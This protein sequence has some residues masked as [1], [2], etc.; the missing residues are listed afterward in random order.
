MSSVDVP[1][2]HRQAAEVIR[3]HLVAHRGG[4]VFLS[5]SDALRLI[6]WLDRE[7]P[8]PDILRAIERAADNRAK[9]RSRV[10]LGL[11]HVGRHLGKPTK[12][13]FKARGAPVVA[14]HETGLAPLVR[15]ICERAPGDAL[16]DR[17]RALADELAALPEGPK[18]AEQAMIR[19]RA[20]HEAVFDGL[21][22]ARRSEL[23]QAARDA[24]AD[25]AHL[26]QERELVPLI[27]EAARYEARRGYLWLSAASVWDLLQPP[28]SS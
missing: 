18:L 22:E 27:E 3:E 14:A 10:P 17:L 8:I 9:K 6:D 19:V 7:I 2:E 12:G 16:E 13:V 4:A 20:F 21:T 28:E 11:G 26:M 1:P 15:L 25:L 5:S 24:V 23:R